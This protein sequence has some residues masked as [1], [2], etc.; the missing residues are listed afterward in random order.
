MTPTAGG[1]FSGT[2]LEALESAVLGPLKAEFPEAAF[3]LDTERLAGRGYYDDLCCEIKVA[4]PSGE[5][6]SIADGGFVDWTQ[7]LMANRKERLLISGL[8]TER[9]CY[10]FGKRTNPS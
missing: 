2:H 3:S 8:G 5:V 10:L 7:K 9:L 6:Y 1:D 4:G